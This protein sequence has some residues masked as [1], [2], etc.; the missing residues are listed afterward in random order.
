MQI[1]LKSIIC[2]ATLDLYVMQVLGLLLASDLFAM[3]G[4]Y[5]TIFPLET[6]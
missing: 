6:K 4:F 3:I 1:R 2:Y 5:K